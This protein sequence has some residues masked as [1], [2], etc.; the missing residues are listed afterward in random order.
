MKK[1][2]TPNQWGEVEISLLKRIYPTA[3]TWVLASI[4]GRSLISVRKK[5]SK[6]HIKKIVFSKKNK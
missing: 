4:L 2:S 1:L 6:L 5:A 3:P